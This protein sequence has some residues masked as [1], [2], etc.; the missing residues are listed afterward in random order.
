MIHLTETIRMSKDEKFVSPG[1]MPTAFEAELL[2]ILIEECAEVQQRA[3]KVLRFGIDEIQPGQF[4]DNTQ[5][6][7]YE[8]GD[9]LAVI[10]KC[11]DAKLINENIVAAQVPIKLQK[12]VKFM[13]Q[14]NKND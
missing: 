1:T 4:A 14:E 7:S 11:M 13:Q 8:V 3:T 9:L 2:T 5:R 10:D 6:L 12:M